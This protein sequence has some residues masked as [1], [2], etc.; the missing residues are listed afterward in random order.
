VHQVVPLH[1]SLSRRSQ[2]NR[3]R[4]VYKNI[5]ATKAFDCF[6][7]GFTDLQFISDVDYARQAFAAC[8]LDWSKKYRK[9]FIAQNNQ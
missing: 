5:D 8:L 2:I 1:V 3:R 9:F 7:N 4:V 6:F